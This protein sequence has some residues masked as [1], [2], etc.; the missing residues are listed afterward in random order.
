MQP[1]SIV[2]APLLRFE[3]GHDIL[4][5]KMEGISEIGDQVKDKDCHDILAF[6]A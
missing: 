4:L 6:L 5:L 2:T 3:D 1:R